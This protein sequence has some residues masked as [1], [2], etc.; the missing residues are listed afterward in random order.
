METLFAATTKRVASLESQN[1]EL[2]TNVEEKET[3]VVMNTQ[4][5]DKVKSE[6]DDMSKKVAALKKE[7][8]EVNEASEEKVRKVRRELEELE[9]QKT[10]L[11]RRLKS[12][13][14]DLSCK[15]E[16]VAGLKTSVAQLT[17]SSAGMEA[18]LKHTKLVLEGS[19]AKVRHKMT[20]EDVRQLINKVSSLGCRVDK[21]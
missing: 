2:Q 21:A 15:M 18:D 12:V 9:Y 7:L 1:T 3:K 11:E 14:D 8:E 6:N 20:K 19:Q 13:E 16:E 4:E 5:L 17:S 10:T